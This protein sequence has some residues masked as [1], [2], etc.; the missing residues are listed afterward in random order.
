MKKT[1]LIVD[2]EMLIRYSLIK[3]LQGMGLEA[4]A[5]PT[6]EEAVAEISERQYDLCLLDMILPG[7]PGL[8]V[9]QAIHENSPGTKVIVITGCYIDD[10][11]SE[12]LRTAD[13]FITK[14]FDIYQVRRLANE[15]LFGNGIATAAVKPAPKTRI[16][17]RNPASEAVYFKASYLD[18]GRIHW[19]VMEGIIVNK[20]E[21]GI[22]M[23]TKQP[24]EV[25]RVL[26]IGHGN[27]FRA[28]I[29]RWS[30]NSSDKDEFRIGVEFI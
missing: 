14:P 8:G 18:E 1:A 25:G 26:K 22:G 5:V 29:V 9:M 2:S 27:I 23:I 21:R 3:A 13:Y 7:I 6:G 4:A 28:G 12:G 16:A 10:K 11:I 19:A 20:S 17:L 24:F 30:C 15:A